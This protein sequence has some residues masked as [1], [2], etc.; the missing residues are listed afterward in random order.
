[1]PVEKKKCA[2]IARKKGGCNHSHI[3][4][5]ALES[6]IIGG[7]RG[8]VMRKNLRGSFLFCPLFLSLPLAI[9]AKMPELPTYDYRVPFQDTS[10]GM[11]YV[12]MDSGILA[13]E[14]SLVLRLQKFLEKRKLDMW[15]DK[16]TKVALFS[17]PLYAHPKETIKKSE[18]K[19]W[20]D[21]FLAEYDSKKNVVWIFPAVPAKRKKILVQANP[22]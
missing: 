9:S 21:H 6:G 22:S 14:D 2:V 1:M 20:A 18:R 13:N 10:S 19:A 11:M 15:G 8:A 17:D 7:K 5:L 12:S 4:V 3:L 16:F